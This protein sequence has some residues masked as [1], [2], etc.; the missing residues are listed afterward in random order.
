MTTLLDNTDIETPVIEDTQEYKLSDFVGEGKKF[1]DESAVAKK[2]VK[3]DEHISRLE[4]EKAELLADLQ[5]AVQEKKANERLEEIKNLLERRQPSESQSNDNNQNRETDRTDAPL[6][7]SQIEKILDQ[8]EVKRRRD[9]NL[10]ETKKRLVETYGRDFPSKV[11]EAASNLSIGV[12][13]LEGI[14]ADS[15]Q[16]FFKL[17]GV[18]SRSPENPITPP[19]SSMTPEFK[20]QTGSVKNMSFYEAMRRSDPVRYHNRETQW[21]MDQMS[22]KLGPDFFK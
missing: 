16:A 6:D 19:R 4:R 9:A 3:S 10:A 15:P 22:Q 1:K 21:E 20:P 17:I 8:R 11:K 7:V 18:E 14:A 13:D 2:I 5:A 12:Q